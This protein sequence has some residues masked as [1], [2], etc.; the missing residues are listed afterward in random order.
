MLDMLTSSASSSTDAPGADDRP[1]DKQSP[2]WQ[3]L[4][5]T[6]AGHLGESGATTGIRPAVGRCDGGSIRLP[7]VVQERVL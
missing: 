2:R 6:I 7:T 3:R 5:S 4:A 1:A